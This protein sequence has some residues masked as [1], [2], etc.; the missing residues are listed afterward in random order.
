MRGSQL[1]RANKKNGEYIVDMVY[2]W[3]WIALIVIFAAVAVLT[4][5]NMFISVS[6]GALIPLIFDIFKADLIFQIIVF[7]AVTLVCLIIVGKRPG[8]PAS[9]GIDSVV[10]AR[11]VVEERI[12]GEAGCGQ[13]TVNGQSWSARSVDESAVYEVGETLKVVAVEGVKL[14]CMK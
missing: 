7:V 13:V 2:G 3:I 8:A 1:G 9:D 10:G 12:D 6:V 5:K 14:I 4:R 11:C